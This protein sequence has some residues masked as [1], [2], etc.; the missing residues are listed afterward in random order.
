MLQ[1]SATAA[2]QSSSTLSSSSSDS[3]PQS[4]EVDNKRNSSNSAM[5]DFM[6]KSAEGSDDDIVLVSNPE[7]DPW[8]TGGKELMRDSSSSVGT[9][10]GLEM[11]RTGGSASSARRILI[12]PESSIVASTDGTSHSELLVDDVDSMRSTSN[13]KQKGASSD[14][15]YYVNEVMYHV[16]FLPSIRMQGNINAYCSSTLTP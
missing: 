7:L 14:Q 5:K 11:K 3:N 4:S 15:L 1:A 13:V 16:S 8:S 12:D 6:T 9:G 10:M 2:L